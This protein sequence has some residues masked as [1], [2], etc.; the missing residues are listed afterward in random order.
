MSPKPKGKFQMSK[1]RS[2]KQLWESVMV[3]IRDREDPKRNSVVIDVVMWAPDI[4]KK[5]VLDP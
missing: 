5:L 1:M 3:V 2:P 4:V